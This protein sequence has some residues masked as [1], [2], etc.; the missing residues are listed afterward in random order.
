MFLISG[1]E[2]ANSR[3]FITKYIYFYNYDRLKTIAYDKWWLTGQYKSQLEN[4]TLT[5]T[6]SL[7]AQI[8][9]RAIPVQSKGKKKKKKAKEELT[10]YWESK[11]HN[12]SASHTKRLSSWC[13]SQWPEIT[14]IF[15]ASQYCGR[16]ESGLCNRVTICKERAVRYCGFHTGSCCP[17]RHLRIFLLIFS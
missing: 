5:I 2:L 10:V 16:Q 15:R 12:Y 7:K 8:I 3:K 17:F 4:M 14:C 6:L 1:N 13:C 9:A 11:E